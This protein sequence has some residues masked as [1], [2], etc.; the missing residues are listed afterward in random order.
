MAHQ[1]DDGNCDFM[2]SYEPA[3]PAWYL[4]KEYI[5]DSEIPEIRGVLGGALIDL[6]TD[7]YS[8]VEMWVQI[9]RDVCR[10]QGGG[11]KPPRAPLLAD[12]PVVK[13]LLK[14]EIRLLLLSLQEKAAKQGRN[15]QAVM[16][17]YSPSVVSYVMGSGQR[18]RAQSAGSCLD[19]QDALSRPQS[20]RSLQEVRSGS[21]L[22]ASSGSE[23]HIDGVKHKLNIKDIHEVVAHLKSVLTEDLEAMKRE[24]QFLQECVEQKHQSQSDSLNQEPTVSELKEERKLIQKELKLEEAVRH[25]GPTGRTSAHYGLQEK[26]RP[27]G[28]TCVSSTGAVVWSPTRIFSKHR[29]P[30]ARPLLV[31]PSLPT[32][33]TARPP[34]RVFDSSHHTQESSIRHGSELPR[35]YCD[36]SE[37][38]SVPEE[39]AVS[40]SSAASGPVGRPGPFP[41]LG[42]DSST[43]PRDSRPTASSRT[44]EE[45]AQTSSPGLS[46]CSPSGSHFPISVMLPLPPA[47]R[48]TRHED[49]ATASP[50][51]VLVPV[52]PAMQKPAA[53]GQSVTRRL[54]LPQGGLV[55]PT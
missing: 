48:Q 16:S 12:S 19:Q 33:T 30:L 18:N 46:K 41:D 23:D 8:E 31:E 26:R 25:P 14:A 35:R 28:Q 32:V 11:A 55:S 52:P 53:R 49:A 45:W 4:L 40:G 29:P 24:I 37:P 21:R 9:W 15:G 50:V 54:R 17:C 44:L 7:A 39:R 10:K 22:S 36:A 5:P 38:R 34:A 2:E 42:L 20:A 51:N 47:Q 1:P 3:P 27:A 13:E 6:C 43:H